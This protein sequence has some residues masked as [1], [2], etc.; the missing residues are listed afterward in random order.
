VKRA[1]RQHDSNIFI[2]VSKFI[3]Q[4]WIIFCAT[5]TVLVFLGGY[6]V[7]QV[8]SQ[9]GVE[10]CP[11][12]TLM[13]QKT[14]PTTSANTD[15]SDLSTIPFCTA[16][17]PK[18]YDHCRDTMYSKDRLFL[19]LA[20]GSIPE[21]VF[22]ELHH[23]ASPSKRSFVMTQE[24]DWPRKSPLEKQCSKIYLT[25]AGSRGSQPNKC[26]AIVKVAEGMAS[27]FQSSHRIGFT[28]LLTG[29]RGYFH[30]FVLLLH[31]II[32]L[33]LL[34]CFSQSP[35]DSTF[36]SCSSFFPLFPFSFLSLSLLF[37]F[38]FFSFFSSL[39]FSLSI[40]FS[41]LS[42]TSSNS[43]FSSHGYHLSKQLLLRNN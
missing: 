21:I 26:T 24:R 36:S 16:D 19:H 17:D 30:F 4:M 12:Y 27:P 41:C 35:S 33:R 28:A 14:P 39:S 40:L 11:N 20:E 6:K 31:L 38:P 9:Y 10:P 5:A 32:M 3:T 13:S 25:R 22:P 7:G 42:P 8:H 34:L 18:V 2:W 1:D 37:A 29:N 43:S 23:P 15:F